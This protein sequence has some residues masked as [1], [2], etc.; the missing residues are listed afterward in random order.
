MNILL[1]TLPEDVTWHINPISLALIGMTLYL[2]FA[3]VPSD[4]KSRLKASW[5]LF[6]PPWQDRS[7]RPPSLPEGAGVATKDGQARAPRSAPQTQA[8]SGT[9]DEVTADG[10]TNGPR[11]SADDSQT[12]AKEKGVNEAGA[13]P[14]EFEEA[15]LVKSR[16][17]KAHHK[18]DLKSGKE[19]ARAATTS[20]QND[21]RSQLEMREK[22]MAQKGAESVANQKSGKNKSDGLDAKTSKSVEL[23]RSLTKRD[24]M[25]QSEQA[26]KEKDRARRQAGESGT[27][28]S[29]K[30]AK[31]TDLAERANNQ[32]TG[33]KRKDELL[34]RA[35]QQAGPNLDE[36]HSLSSRGGTTQSE[37]AAMAKERARRKADEAGN[38]EKIRQA[39]DDGRNDPNDDRKATNSERATQSERARKVK[40]AEEGTADD[41]AVS[42]SSGQA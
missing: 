30:E 13:K 9:R 35:G 1:D 38:S 6:W 18:A 15:T 8:K 33:E 32:S 34:R 24:M 25:A 17:A 40:K 7:G 10:R 39:E 29:I 5:I 21:A 12:K 14:K 41:V 42:S 22:V 23:E 27:S 36:D 31:D 19:T 3:L 4:Q 37:R 26:A 20:Q 16:E 28:D 11:V 2:G